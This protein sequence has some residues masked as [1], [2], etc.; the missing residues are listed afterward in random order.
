MPRSLPEGG[1][2]AAEGGGPRR[3]ALLATAGLLLVW[4]VGSV[5]HLDPEREFGV[6]HGVAPARRVDG[7]WA[8]VPPLLF[9]LSLYERQGV[10]LPLPQAQELMLRSPDGS[11]F[12]FRG[13]VTLR[14]RPESWR[15]LHEAAGGEGLRGALVRALRGA[16]EEL[17][18]SIERG[19][20]T[21][22]LSRNLELR[23]GQELAALGVDLR[24]IELDSV[25]FLA[26]SAG[27]MPAA[28]DT[29]LLVVGLD[30]GD[31]KIIDSLIE[32]NRLPNL[33]RLIEG[34][35]RVK[36]L[37]ISPML[38]PVIWTSVATTSS[39]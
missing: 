22:T 23:L 13:Y 34:G 28:A 15:E 21:A 8:F 38:S 25:D 2:P 1:R 7:P 16:A 3:W 20:V 24:R 6:V 14:A 9:Q 18:G 36:L 39:S 32:Q 31:W 4:L 37:S 17:A 29:K 12:G 10:E 27:E 35:T 26:V 30:G 19:P 5:R 33:Q 11:V